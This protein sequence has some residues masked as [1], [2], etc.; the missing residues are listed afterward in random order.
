[1]VDWRTFYHGKEMDLFYL[2]F[3]CLGVSVKGIIKNSDF[4]SCQKLELIWYFSSY[5]DLSKHYIFYQWNL[6]MIEVRM[7]FNNSVN[8]LDSIA[9]DFE[10]L[11][12]FSLQFMYVILIFGTCRKKNLQRWVEVEGG[13][14]KCWRD[15]EPVGDCSVFYSCNSRNAIFVISDLMKRIHKPV[16]Q[17]IKPSVY[18]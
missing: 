11:N 10:L 15:G 12:E 1:M 7:C 6:M 2:H 16:Q 14:N 3:E 13:W 4:P 9:H 5:L 17:I 8:W 18:V